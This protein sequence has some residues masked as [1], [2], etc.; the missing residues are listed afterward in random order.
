MQFQPCNG[1][2]INIC[3]I[4]LA[5]LKDKML[6][7]VDDHIE[8]IQQHFKNQNTYETPYIFYVPVPYK[9]K[10][11]ATKELVV[12]LNNVFTGITISTYFVDKKLDKI[13][14]HT[15]A[16]CYCRFSNVKYCKHIE[17][18]YESPGCDKTFIKISITASF[19]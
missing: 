6:D 1:N 19:S 15:P 2:K 5:A 12:A 13:I 3:D 9:W 16:T 18:T 11:A 17:Q 14:Q 7:V 8:P 4:I 10:Y